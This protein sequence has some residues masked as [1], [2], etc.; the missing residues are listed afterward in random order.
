MR[1]PIAVMALLF[2]LG[3]SDESKSDRDTVAP[4]ET[5]ASSDDQP[6]AE[7]ALLTIDDVPTGWTESAVPDEGDDVAAAR[8]EVRDCYGSGPS[9]PI[10]IGGA[11]AGTGQ[12]ESPDDESV[13]HD[14]AIG[15]EQ[16]AMDLMASLA[17]DSVASCL[18]SAFPELLQLALDAANQDF[19]LTDVTVGRLSV[20]PAGDEVVAYRVDITVMAGDESVDVFSDLVV[21]RVG[22]GLSALQFQSSLLPFSATDI[23]D[24]V[25]LTTDR[26]REALADGS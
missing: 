15:D 7:A 12:F 24:Y 2:V 23:D 9:G 1:A 16:G 22:R 26:L 10:D 19:E 14:V 18:E 20:A 3:C 4:V 17:D 6:I 8:Q 25:A 13:K 21:V 5:Q 11:Q